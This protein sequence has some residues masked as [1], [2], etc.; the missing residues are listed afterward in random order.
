M[1]CI[2]ALTIWVNPRNFYGSYSTGVTPDKNTNKTTSLKPRS[3]LKGDI[4]EKWGSTLN[5]RVH[6][7]GYDVEL[8][9]KAPCNNNYPLDINSS[10]TYDWVPCDQGSDHDVLLQ[11]HFANNLEH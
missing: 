5:L 4:L 3:G 1:G 8:I 2:Y 6:A 7:H 11:F 10:C 9:M